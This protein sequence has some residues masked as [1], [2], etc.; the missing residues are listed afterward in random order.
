MAI[1]T[2]AARP[3][4]FGELDSRFKDGKASDQAIR[5]YLMT[6]KFI[7][8]AADAAI[9]CYRETKQLAAVELAGYTPIVE[10]EPVEE[11]AVQPKQT[12]IQ[13]PK[14]PAQLPAGEPYR[15]SITADGLEVVARLNDTDSIERL[16]RILEAGKA[17]ITPV[18]H[19][20]DTGEGDAE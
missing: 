5:S 16:I 12:S 15:V 7:P 8:A 6:Q 14:P 3:E 19:P 20:F 18:A 11:A 4:L 10:E 13:H 2:A 1:R 9:R 17:L